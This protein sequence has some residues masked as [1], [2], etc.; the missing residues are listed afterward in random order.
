[1][2]QIASTI[3]SAVQQQGSATQGIS[4]NAQHAVVGARDVST[5]IADM[6]NGA[7]QTGNAASRVLAAA[8]SLANDSEKLKTQAKHFLDR[9][10]A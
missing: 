6:R 4:S 3:A 5:N 9:L 2:S 8:G 10:R 7:A 1:M